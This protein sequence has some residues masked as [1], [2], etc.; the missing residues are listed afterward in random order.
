MCTYLNLVWLPRWN[1]YINSHGSLRVNRND[2][3]EFS[4]DFV[5]WLSI[6]TRTLNYNTLWCHCSSFFQA[7][8]IQVNRRSP[9]ENA[10]KVCGRN[11]RKNDGVRGKSFESGSKH[12]VAKMVRFRYAIFNRQQQQKIL[13]KIYL[14]STPE[15]GPLIFLVEK[16]NH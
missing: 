8:A 14:W 5:S 15:T 10:L 6:V 16:W 11:R 3:T 12:I 4:C 9:R 13:R 2:C 1:I 7:R